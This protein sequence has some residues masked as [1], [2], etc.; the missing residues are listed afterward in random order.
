MLTLRRL[1]RRE[2]LARGLVVLAVQVSLL[3]PPE[4]PLD[5][6]MRDLSGRGPSKKASVGLALALHPVGVS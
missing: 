3:S 5:P 4:F 2:P 1:D 6:R